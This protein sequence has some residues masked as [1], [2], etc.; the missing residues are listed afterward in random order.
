M[1]L[2]DF[3]KCYLNIGMLTH[4]HIVVRH[5]D[6]METSSW[7]L[8]CEIQKKMQ[9]ISATYG[10]LTME[11]FIMFSETETIVIN[12]KEESGNDQSE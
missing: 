2:D 12:L 1:T 5:S 7:V 6:G 9:A 10:D 11:S 4:I 8:C 3:L